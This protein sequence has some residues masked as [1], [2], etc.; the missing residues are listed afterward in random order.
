DLLHRAGFLA[1]GEGEGVDADGAAAVA[2]DQCVERRAVEAVEAELV[3]V[4]DQQG[5]FGDAEVDAAVGV[6]VGEVADAAQQPVRDA[7][8]A[9]GAGGDLHGRVPG[10]PDAEDPGGAG[11]DLGQVGHVV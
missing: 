3:D 11:D 4:E 5:R 8:G 9:A 7:R 6:D 2:A 10:H 1:D